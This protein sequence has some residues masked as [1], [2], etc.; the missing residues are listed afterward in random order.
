[1]FKK[2]IIL[3]ILCLFAACH[4]NDEIIE[5]P[6]S[7]KNE[8]QEPKARVDIILSHEEQAMSESTNDF[9]FQLFK[10]VCVSENR[11]TNIFIS[12][13]SVSLCL[14][15]S[16][17]GANGNT[18]TE[19]KKVLGFSSSSMDE[20]NTYNQKLMSS[21]LNI[22]NTTQIGIAN[23]VW[24]NQGFVVKNTFIDINKLKYNA[25]VESLDFSSA[26][27]IATINAWC[28]RNTENRLVDI[29]DEISPEARLILINALYF[30]GKWTNP[31]SKEVTKNDFFTNIDGEQV[32]VDMMCQEESFR[33][34]NNEKFAI[35]E[36]PYGNE[37]FSMVVV[38]PVENS[39]LEESLLWLSND[40]WKQCET[41]M[42]YQKL[43]VKMPKFSFKYQKPLNSDMSVLGMKDA[44]ILGL[45]DFRN[46]S[47]SE[48]LYLSSLEQFTYL[49]VNEEGTE[50]A[51]ITTEVPATSTGDDKD[52]IHFFMD[53][54]FIFMIK[55]KSTGLILF[56]GQVTKL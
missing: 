18:L 4:S 51:A 43:Q 3:G 8:Q 27:A 20:V 53:R 34:M 7:P 9:A 56:M 49:E 45:A 17:N 16:A 42:S 35:A 52:I 22:D 36:F 29:M 38:L 32:K 2:E 47:A 6:E 30:K 44:F 25:W 24:I 55:E 46:I 31:F 13:F 50:S 15:M 11:K 28:A 54:P 26:S 12:P 33:C 14:S 40:A 5:E 41:Q 23:S 48:N 21:L 37:A 39:S 1:M 10:Q 19:I